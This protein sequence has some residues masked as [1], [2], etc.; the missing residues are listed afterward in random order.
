[1]PFI[2]FWHR[3]ITEGEIET[4]G[5]RS[6]SQEYQSKTTIILVQ[7]IVERSEEE[8]WSQHGECGACL[9]LEEVVSILN[10]MRAKCE[11]DILCVSHAHRCYE[12]PERHWAHTTTAVCLNNGVTPQEMVQKM[13]RWKRENKWS[14]DV[15]Q[16]WGTVQVRI[17]VGLPLAIPVL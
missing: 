2:A 17:L 6:M 15:F 7:G 1:M 11:V 8:Q 16:A 14:L 4:R 5:A 9:V 13:N 3:Q 12:Y 10:A